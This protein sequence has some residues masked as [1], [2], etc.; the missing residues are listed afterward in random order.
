MTIGC[1]DHRSGK[2]AGVEPKLGQFCAKTLP[3]E[4]GYN[5]FNYLHEAGRMG[6]WVAHGGLSD[7]QR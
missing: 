5:R 4:F 7:W 2:R 6:D 3:F 1:L